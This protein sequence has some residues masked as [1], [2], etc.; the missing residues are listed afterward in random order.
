MSKD[1]KASFSFSRIRFFTHPPPH[2]SKPYEFLE[3]SAL[4]RIFAQALCTL[5]VVPPRPIFLFALMSELSPYAGFLNNP[6]RSFQPFAFC[7]CPLFSLRRIPTPKRRSPFRSFFLHF[8]SFPSSAFRARISCRIV[9]ALHWPG[10]P[11]F[12]SIALP[13]RLFTFF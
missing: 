13:L 6:P 8:S 1:F 2:T 12:F 10:F 3:V 7:S 9:L 5:K 11:S 4:F